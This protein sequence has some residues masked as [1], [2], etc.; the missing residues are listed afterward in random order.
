MKWLT[1]SSE[2]FEPIPKIEFSFKKPLFAA[3]V[4]LDYSR[5]AGPL[6]AHAELRARIPLKGDVHYS[7]DVVGRDLG[8]LFAFARVSERDELTTLGREFVSEKTSY[9]I[10]TVGNHEARPGKAEQ[11][12]NVVNESPAQLLAHLQ[13]LPAFQ[14]AH[15]RDESLYGGYIAIGARIEALRIE[16]VGDATAVEN[17][18]VRTMR[19]P[20]MLNEK[21]W[22]SLAWETRTAYG[23][24]FDVAKKTLTAASFNLPI[25]GKIEIKA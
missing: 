5:K 4:V 22:S 19:V 2:K 15:A 17:Y 23:F 12:V 14:Q 21:Q 9:V 11:V 10:R 13:T 7:V 3:S 1:L 20:R 16:R 6:V 25:I 24:K 18:E 8:H